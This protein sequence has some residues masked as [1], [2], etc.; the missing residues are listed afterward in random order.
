MLLLASITPHSPPSS[1]LTMAKEEKVPGVAKGTTIPRTGAIVQQPLRKVSP[2]FHD[3]IKEYP[4]RARDALLILTLPTW[5]HHGR[6]KRALNGL[7]S[8]LDAE[9]RLKPPQTTEGLRNRKREATGIRD[10]S[11]VRRA[12]MEA[13]IW[14]VLLLSRSVWCEGE[15]VCAEFAGVLVGGEGDKRWVMGRGV[16]R[17]SRLG[18]AVY[19]RRRKAG[20]GFVW[21]ERKEAVAKMLERERQHWGGW[22]E[23]RDGL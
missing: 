6:R 23:V 10:A 4:C 14:S 20:R 16:E 2:V 15:R 1:R 13:R 21:V 11:T 7:K 18:V 9:L 19:V 3:C 17:S 5:E 8:R 12:R 22:R